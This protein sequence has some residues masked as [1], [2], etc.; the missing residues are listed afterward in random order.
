MSDVPKKGP[1]NKS[2]DTTSPTPGSVFKNNIEGSTALSG[3][4]RT[5][6]LS[7]GTK[8]TGSGQKTDE[9]R[10]KLNQLLPKTPLADLLYSGAR[11]PIESK[12]G[13]QREL[14]DLMSNILRTEQDMRFSC[15]AMFEETLHR[16]S[17][18]IH[19]LERKIGNKIRANSKSKAI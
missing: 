10:V 8:I 9:F 2:R 13:Y 15:E 17:L 19:E 7:D 11:L 12:L 4:D 14:I 1:I 3:H 5:T 6:G 18:R 16:D